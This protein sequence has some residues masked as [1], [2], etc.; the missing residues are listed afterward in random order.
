MSLYAFIDSHFDWGY[1]IESRFSFT[2]SV[3]HLVNRPHEHY[4]CILRESVLSETT[5]Y[6]GFLVGGEGYFENL[7]D[8]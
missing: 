6:D 3:T 8:R 7:V 2:H 5:L 4:S 1:K